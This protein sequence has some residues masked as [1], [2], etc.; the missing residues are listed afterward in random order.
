M[1]GSKGS[2]E[3]IPHIRGVRNTEYR[4]AWRFFL[5]P[6]AFISKGNKKEKSQLGKNSS[7]DDW[8]MVDQLCPYHNKHNGEKKKIE[9]QTATCSCISTTEFAIQALCHIT[10]PIPNY[11]SR[12]SQRVWWPELSKVKSF[13]TRP[14]LDESLWT[15][16]FSLSAGPILRIRTTILASTCISVPFQ[17]P[18]GGSPRSTPVS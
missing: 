5:S 9:S 15:N 8:S 14:C 1:F 16:P 17:A 11:T 18:R 4:T 2:S 6:L 12:V 10:F 7:I 3:L 13:S